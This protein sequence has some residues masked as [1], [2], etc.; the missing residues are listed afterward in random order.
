MKLYLDFKCFLNEDCNGHG[1]CDETGT[2]QCQEKWNGKADCSGK[3]CNKYCC[4]NFD[5]TKLKHKPLKFQSLHVKKMLTAMV[6]EHV[7]MENVSAIQ[8][9]M[10]RKIVQ[11][12]L[13]FEI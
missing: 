10:Q 5:I 11:V 1:V 3:I 12:I 6:K 9:G 13:L 4:L 2:C 7:K 8:N